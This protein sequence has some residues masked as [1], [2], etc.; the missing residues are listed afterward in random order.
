MLEILPISE[1]NVLEIV[2]GIVFSLVSLGVTM[3]LFQMKVERRTYFLWGFILLTFWNVLETIDELFIKNASRELIFNVG[4]RIVLLV[5]IVV[6]IF[7]MRTFTK[8]QTK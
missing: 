8:Q 7:A 3:Y 1:F 2:L 6:L 5:G 4:G